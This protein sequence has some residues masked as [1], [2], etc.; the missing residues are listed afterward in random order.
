[1][2]HRENALNW[3]FWQGINCWRRRLC[4]CSPNTD[5]NEDCTS[6]FNELVPFA[7]VGTRSFACFM[8][9]QKKNLLRWTSKRVYNCRYHL[10]NQITSYWNSIR[11]INHRRFCL[12]PSKSIPRQEWRSNRIILVSISHIWR[13]HWTMLSNCLSLK[14]I[15]HV[16]DVCVVCVCVRVVCGMSVQT[17]QCWCATIHGLTFRVRCGRGECGAAEGDEAR[18]TMTMDHRIIY[19]WN[20]M[21]ALPPPCI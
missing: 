16:L 6:S 19:R 17:T 10:N 9:K 1:M 14:V 12:Q 15:L 21:W 20:T 5:C 4:S 3:L 11:N 7:F 2:R 8:E 18:T 13:T